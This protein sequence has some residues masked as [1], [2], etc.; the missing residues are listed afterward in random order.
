MQ[1][2]TSKGALERHEM[3]GKHKFPPVDLKTRLHEI[4]LS[5]KTSFSLSIGSM[6]NRSKAAD[7]F[8]FKVI[9]GKEINQC[10]WFEK[11]CYSLVRKTPYR[12]SQSLLDDLEALFLAGYQRDHTEMSAANKYTPAQALS[13][14]SNLRL[15][16][17]RRKYSH[18]KENA[19]GALPSIK[20]I[21]SWFAR[22]VKKGNEGQLNFNVKNYGAMSEDNIRKII[23]S[24]FCLGRISKKALLKSMLDAYHV[25]NYIDEEYESTKG[26]LDSSQMKLICAKLSLPDT[27]N[28][29]KFLVKLLELRD[30]CD[31]MEKESSD[32]DEDDVEDILQ[33]VES[34]DDYENCSEE[35]LKE[36]VLEV[37]GMDINAALR[38]NDL[39]VACLRVHD[40]S[41]GEFGN[42][43]SS[44]VQELENLC[45]KK[46]RYHGA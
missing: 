10:H 44:N 42:R 6:P 37:L 14:L 40:E 46:K 25:L 39:L 9:D 20:Y 16:D 31:L 17:G 32:I 5:G 41:M 43:Y 36:K 26:D 18:D 28:D 19:N 45:R 4:H 3:N 33:E 24:R 23:K 15:G 29:K 1:T 30:Q 34:W 7:N 8:A 27:Y 22:R 12:A 2:F 11:G 13:F 35:E 38:E 21:K